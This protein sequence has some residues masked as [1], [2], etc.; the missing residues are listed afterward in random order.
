MKNN[1]TEQQYDRIPELLPFLLDYIRSITTPTPKAGKN[2]FVCPLCGSGSH[3]AKTGAFGYE[4]DSKTGRAFWHC[5]SCGNGGDIVS[6]YKAVNGC[7]TKTAINSLVRKYLNGNYEAPV[8]KVNT[9]EQAAEEKR[10]EEFIKR[11][12]GYF[13]R[14]EYLAEGMTATNYL[15]KRGISLSTASRFGIK[16]NAGYVFYPSI[17]FDYIHAR[18]ILTTNKDFKSH[19]GSPSPFNFEA[20]KETNKPVFVVEGQADALSLEEVGLKSV[21]ICS[22]SNCHRFVEMLRESEANPALVLMLDNDTEKEK[23][24]ER[25]VNAVEPKFLQ[26]LISSGFK[27]ISIDREEWGYVDS[28]PNDWLKRDRESL[29]RL[30]NL[31]MLYFHRKLDEYK[32]NLAEHWQNEEESVTEPDCFAAEQQALM[33]HVKAKEETKRYNSKS[34]R[35]AFANWVP[36]SFADNE[37]DIDAAIAEEVEVIST[38]FP[39]LDSVLKGG[40]LSKGLYLFGAPPA[41]GK[42]AFCLQIADH[43]ASMGHKVLYYSLEMSAA[44]LKTRTLARLTKVLSMD[45]DGDPDK[46]IIPLSLSQVEKVIRYGQK[47]EHPA[48]FKSYD[49]IKSNLYGEYFDKSK[50]TAEVIEAQIDK[51]AAMFADSKPVVVIDYLQLIRLEN[52]KQDSDVLQRLSDIAALLKRLSNLC[53]ILVIS[54]VNRASYKEVSLGSFKGSGDLEFSAN[55]AAVLTVTDEADTRERELSLCVVKSRAG[56]GN[57]DIKFKFYG[58]NLW[59][60]DLGQVTRHGEETAIKAIKESS[61]NTKSKYLTDE[62]I[63]ALMG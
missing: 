62:Q 41:T 43:I 25:A 1:S 45:R 49:R 26:E 54:S 38:G 20:V 46:N 6:L 3:G 4:V 17:G 7:D 32:D 23:K 44:E 53:P 50:P 33:V 12:K 8:I 36:S 2:K 31:D 35:D 63:S 30:N 47:A 37:T 19:I 11:W 59:F 48:L 22:T 24:E 61:K 52:P 55:F 58:E 60:K 57:V 51:F 27:A 14:A 18:G 28:D 39:S 42:S 16:G 34:A 40:G 10:K 5:F 15:A 9:E 29:A 56:M 21:A 13:S